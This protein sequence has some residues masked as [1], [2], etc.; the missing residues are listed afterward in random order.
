MARNILNPNWN[1]IN[2][3]DI[4]KEQKQIEFKNLIVE[5]QQTGIMQQND[6]PLSPE[7]ATIHSDNYFSCIH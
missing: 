3:N 2:K 6:E 1:T 5:K 7:S 4:N